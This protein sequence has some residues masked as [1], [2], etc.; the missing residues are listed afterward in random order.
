MGKE[1]AVEN[2]I[3]TLVEE[4]R[5]AFRIPENL[6]HYMDEDYKFAEKQFIKF[7]LNECRLDYLR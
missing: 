1:T 2:G 7:A 5:T 3:R 4:Y 6:D